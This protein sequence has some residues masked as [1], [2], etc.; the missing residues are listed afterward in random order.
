MQ[1][2]CGD[3][4]AAA[5]AMLAPIEL[6]SMSYNVARG[7]SWPGLS[8]P[9]MAFAL[10]GAKQIVPHFRFRIKADSKF[11]ARMWDSALEKAH[12]MCAILYRCHTVPFVF[13]KVMLSGPSCHMKP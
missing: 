13:L 9:W 6:L 5:A 8:A 4:E 3:Q 10:S 1:G 7:L 11:C 2:G 12:V